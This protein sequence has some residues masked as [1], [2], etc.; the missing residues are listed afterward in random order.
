MIIQVADSVWLNDTGVCSVEQLA[1][2][3][4]LSVDE[5]NDLVENGVIPPADSNAHPRSYRLQYVITARTARRLRDDFELDRHGVAL[6]LTLMRRIDLL[7]Q[8][9]QSARGKLR[10]AI[11]Y[12]GSR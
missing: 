9:L 11:T 1:E 10:Q 12:R 7:E 3:S 2:A 6:A 8:E 4:G 5:V